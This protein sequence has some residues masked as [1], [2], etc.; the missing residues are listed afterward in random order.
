M[1]RADLPSESMPLRRIILALF[2][3]LIFVFLVLPNFVVIPLS[4]SPA[5]YLEF[6]PRAL[7]LRW[8]QEYFARQE[9]VA[10]TLASFEVGT[11]VTLCSVTLGSLAAYGL[12]RG[13]F[14]G[15]NFLNSL[16]ISP[17]VVP[18]LVIAVAIYKLY[19]D[20][21]LTGTLLGFVL[22]HTV[23]ATPFVVII[24]SATLRGIDVQ[25][26]QAAMSLGANRLTT[27]RRVV[28]P[29]VLPGILSAGLFAFLISFDE[30]LIALFISSPTLVTLPKK[31]WDGIR[32]EINP[33]IAAVSTLL[34]LLSLLVLLGTV[35]VSRV[36]EKRSR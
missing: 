23:L 24:V 2:C 18:S 15:R 34:V 31:I 22:A 12:V 14:P 9:W 8:Y 3:G 21:R 7:S 32:T 5:L 36:F 20:L 4:F 13:R 10:A 1:S 17:M 28:F 25:I 33:T 35:V 19:S 11:L 16:I 26:E 6:P 30:L 29:L 27:L